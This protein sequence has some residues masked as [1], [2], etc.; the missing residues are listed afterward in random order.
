MRCYVSGPKHDQGM[1]GVEGQTSQPLQCLLP[2]RPSSIL[3]SSLHSLRG[4]IRSRLS[5]DV[6]V[7]GSQRRRVTVLLLIP[8]GI[9]RVVTRSG[10]KSVGGGCLERLNRRYC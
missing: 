3:R 8:V 7:S 5:S 9:K 4:S 6:G 1:R 2:V 10:R